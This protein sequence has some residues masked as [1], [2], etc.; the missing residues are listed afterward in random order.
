ML[1]LGKEL[2]IKSPVS[3][4]GYNFSNIFLSGCQHNSSRHLSMKRSDQRQVVN[5]YLVNYFDLF[6]LKPVRFSGCTPVCTA[7]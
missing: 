2:Q 5:H 4:K 1:D 3:N 7:V 6:C